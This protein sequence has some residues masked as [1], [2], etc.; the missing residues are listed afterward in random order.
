[1]GWVRVRGEVGRV[2]LARSGHLYFDLK[3]DRAVLSCMTWKGQISGLSVMPEEG[4]EIVAEGKMT[5]SGFQSKFA[6]NAQKVAI[7]GEG[8]LMAM[9]ER[10]KKAL[11]AEGLFAPERKQPL[12]YLPGIIGAW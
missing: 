2:T 6:L 7:A 1:M 10:R 5:A 11:T 9:L 12:P 4:M 3:D 8:A